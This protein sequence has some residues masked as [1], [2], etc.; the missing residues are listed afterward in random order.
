MFPHN[1]C[2]K[3]KRLQHPWLFILLPS[4]SSS[5][6]KGNLGTAGLRL[7]MCSRAKHLMRNSY[8]LTWLSKY[9]RRGQGGRGGE[10]INRATLEPVTFSVMYTLSIFGAQ[11]QSSAAWNHFKQNEAR[12][13]YSCRDMVSCGA[14][15]CTFHCPSLLDRCEQ[16]GHKVRNKRNQITVGLDMKYDTI[17]LWH[18]FYFYLLKTI[19]IIYGGKGKEKLYSRFITP[20]K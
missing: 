4:S 6:V 8:H 3:H 19:N 15:Q 18:G 1:R 20:N 13:S 7:L 17:N 12:F 5:Y 2:R 11:W 9:I 10:W 14:D 16:K